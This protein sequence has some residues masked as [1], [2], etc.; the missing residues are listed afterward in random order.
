[1]P[2]L[3]NPRKWTAFVIFTSL[4]RQNIIIEKLRP[5]I[6]QF[7]HYNFNFYY[8]ELSID[9]LSIRVYGKGKKELENDINKLLTGVE[10][11]VLQPYNYKGRKAYEAATRCV[12]NL[13]KNKR[14]YSGI[15][16][17]E[18]IHG[19][20]DNLC[21]SD[22]QEGKLHLK[23]AWHFLVKKPFYLKI[24]KFKIKLKNLFGRISKIADGYNR[25]AD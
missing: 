4:K 12:F 1:M 17:M 8:S 9:H 13:W 3:Y 14:Y 23:M 20:F 19:I 16:S 24:R 25:L 2:N 5:I 6:E 22:K 7:P 18:F 21:W 10:V 15:N 11:L